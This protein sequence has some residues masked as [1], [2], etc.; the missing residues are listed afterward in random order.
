VK[1]ARCCACGGASSMASTGA[2]F[3]PSDADL[4]HLSD[5]E[6]AELEDQLLLEG[7][8]DLSRKAQFT[9]G[10]AVVWALTLICIVIAMALLSRL[11][12]E[13]LGPLNI[14][15]YLAALGGGAAAAH[16]LWRAAGRQVRAGIRWVLRHWPVALYLVATVWQALRTG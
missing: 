15:L 7:E 9:A 12:T 10:R 3:I 5:V 16:L 11:P 14:P 6:L 4:E 2:L 13:K 1:C 8:L